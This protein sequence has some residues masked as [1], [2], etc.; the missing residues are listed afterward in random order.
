MNEAA[1]G[2]RGHFRAGSSGADCTALL[3]WRGLQPAPPRQ[4]HFQADMQEFSFEWVVEA[5]A[6][7]RN[8]WLRRQ[9]AEKWRLARVPGLAA[10]SVG[11]L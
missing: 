4:P 11:Q 7:S 2:E 8:E 6:T 10:V 5:I 9:S 3:P 1:I